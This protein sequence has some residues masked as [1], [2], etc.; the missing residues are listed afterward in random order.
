MPSSHTGL[1]A[2][3]VVVALATFTETL[4]PPELGVSAP[5]EVLVALT[6][7]GAGQQNAKDEST[8]LTSVSSVQAAAT[9]AE[10]Q[11]LEEESGAPTAVDAPQALA[12]L[13]DPELLGPMPRRWRSWCLK[14][15][16]VQGARDGRSPG[17]PEAL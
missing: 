6:P 14:G 16:G 3:Q 17:G 1:G 9:G 2:G 10:Q 13:P 11:K 12:A 8:S 15:F 7:T 5:V 4:P